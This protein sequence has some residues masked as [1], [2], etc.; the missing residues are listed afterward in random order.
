LTVY[1]ILSSHPSAR[2][3]KRLIAD[4]SVDLEY[5]DYKTDAIMRAW[6]TLGSEQCPTI[7][8]LDSDSV[9]QRAI[10]DEYAESNGLLKLRCGRTPYRLI[11]AIPQAETILF[12]DRDGLERALGRKVAD[13]DWFEARFRPRAVLSRLL[14]DGDYDEKALAFIDAL[15]EAALRRMAQ[16]EIV[17]E[18]REFIEEVQPKSRR[19]RVRRAG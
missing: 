13:L 15:D 4:S 7:V 11:L 5:A 12:S 14:G 19:S 2:L 6:G 18:I 10:V 3:V 8:L 9:E 17:Q 16:H 1:I